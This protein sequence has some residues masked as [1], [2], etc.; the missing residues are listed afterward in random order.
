MNGGQNSGN[1]IRKRI[2]VD[3]KEDRKELYEKSSA[4]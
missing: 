1:G 4:I 2:F 3:L